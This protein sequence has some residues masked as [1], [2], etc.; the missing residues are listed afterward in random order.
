MS[1]R[2]V[3]KINIPAIE[4]RI[5]ENGWTNASFCTVKMQGRSRGWITE[6]KRGKNFPSPEEAANIC[7]CLN[8]APE[9]I[10]ITEDD[11]QLVR[12]ILTKAEGAPGI[13]TPPAE[14]GGEEE[15][16]MELFAELFKRLP[17]SELWK[18]AALA[19]TMAASASEEE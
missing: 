19:T 1:K 7:V 16:S 18:V 15:P 11:I 17:K 3:V 8:T 6:W 10:L 2:T 14:A 5:K 13:K 9:E 12:E 4:Q